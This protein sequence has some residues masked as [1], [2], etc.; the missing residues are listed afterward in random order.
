M[1]DRKK[2]VNLADRQASFELLKKL[3]GSEV[4]DDQ[5]SVKDSSADR[6]AGTSCVHAVGRDST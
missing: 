2:F 5:L 6:T 4:K 1:K 3:Y